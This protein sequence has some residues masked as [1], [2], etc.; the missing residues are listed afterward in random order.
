[1]LNKISLKTLILTSYV[2]VLSNFIFAQNTSMPKDLDGGK[3]TPKSTESKNK[4]KSTENDSRNLIGISVGHMVRKMAVISYE[5][6]INKRFA[7]RLSLGYCLGKD[8]ADGL[9]NEANSDNDPYEKKTASTYNIN[10]DYIQS[11]N[12]YTDLT[13]KIYTNMKLADYYDI[14]YKF[15]VGINYRMYKQTFA[16]N[17]SEDIIPTN[18]KNL[19]VLSTGTQLVI[20][21]MAYREDGLAMEYYIGI[22]TKTSSFHEMTFNPTSNRYEYVSKKS[23]EKN[24]LLTFGLIYGLSF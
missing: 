4:K 23:N 1:M 6:A 3:Y 20:G 13:G 9:L 16:F 5:R 7:A 15:Y 22:G 2:C 21:Q 24:L 17:R 8:R 11:N 10:N 14:E 18:V 19:P 12:F